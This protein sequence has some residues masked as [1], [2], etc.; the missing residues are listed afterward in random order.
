[1][2]SECHTVHNSEEG[3]PMRYDGVALPAGELLRAEDA[4]HLCLTCHD[5]SRLDA[6]DVVAPVTY[7]ADPAGGWFTENPLGQDNPNGHDLL[8]VSPVLA[9]G[10]Q[11]RMILTCVSCHSP[12]GNANF[13]N[14]SAEPP[15]SGAGDS[16]E[17]V[18]AGGDAPSVA[19]SGGQIFRYLDSRR[20]RGGSGPPPYDPGGLRY[21]SGMSAWCN[22][23]H[24][25]FH[26]RTSGEEGTAAPWLRHPQEA[27]ISGSPGADFKHWSGTLPARVRVETPTDDQIPSPDDRVFCLSCHKAHGSAHK[28]AL[29]HTGN[30]SMLDT[31]QQCH[32][33]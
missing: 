21:K 22:D 29:I 18:V 2:C 25:D 10:S 12:H 14:L 4:T 27:T 3:L 7:L 6:P 5:G 23:C 13:R 33:Q 11:D 24:G 15:G 16:L 8:S 20:E 1:V 32:N 26:G 31:C 28:S 30:T 17:V 19:K 9:P